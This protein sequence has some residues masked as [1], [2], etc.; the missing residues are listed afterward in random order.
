MSLSLKLL[1]AV[2]AHP[3][4]LPSPALRAA[5][6]CLRIDNLSTDPEEIET[7]VSITGAHD[8]HA[9]ACTEPSVGDEC[10]QAGFLCEGSI[11][12]TEPEAWI[13]IQWTD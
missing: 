9:D 5:P 12:G 3:L 4:F 10:I 1:S 6:N 2:R 11:A 7:S 13:S 8:T